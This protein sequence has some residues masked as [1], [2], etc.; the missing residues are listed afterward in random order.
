MA[1]HLVEAHINRVKALVNPVEPP[2]D[3]LEPLL[4]TGLECAPV[5]SMN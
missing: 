3:C 1:W 5:L 2:D 4:D